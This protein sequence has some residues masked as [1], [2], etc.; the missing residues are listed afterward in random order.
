MVTSGP[1]HYAEA[2]RLLDKVNRNK[3]D[4]A[5]ASRLQRAQVHAQLALVAATVQAGQLSPN[6]VREWE[7]GGLKT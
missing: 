7:R 3:D 1:D 5:N 4:P 2:Q 6:Q